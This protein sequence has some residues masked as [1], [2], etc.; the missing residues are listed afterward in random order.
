MA[1]RIQGECRV[2]AHIPTLPLCLLG[3]LARCCSCSPLLLCFPDAFPPA[4][5]C[6]CHEGHTR[7]GTGAAYH[8][9]HFGK[10]PRWV[11]T[12]SM[13]SMRTSLYIPLQNQSKYTQNTGVCTRLHALNPHSAYKPRQSIWKVCL[14]S[15]AGKAWDRF[16][17]RQ[18]S[19][20]MTCLAQVSHGN[21]HLRHAFR[22]R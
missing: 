19:L 5:I 1:D 7:L 22:T 21:T 20:S 14:Y 13:A 9:T 3:S 10:L 4:H 18:N 11:C 2:G 15:Q 6:S 8:N 17:P 12:K 16:L